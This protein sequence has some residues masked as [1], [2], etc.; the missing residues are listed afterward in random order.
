LLLVKM[1]LSGY[2]PWGRGRREYNW[3]ALED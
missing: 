3:K 2:S 1:F